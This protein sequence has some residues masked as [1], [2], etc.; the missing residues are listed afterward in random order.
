G[1]NGNNG[2][3]GVFRYIS[4][5][6]NWTSTLG[7]WQR[8]D[9]YPANYGIGLT[10]FGGEDTI[11]YDN[12]GIPTGTH[13][14]LGDYYNQNGPTGSA[15]IPGGF[16][17]SNNY[18]W[19]YSGYFHLSEAIEVS[20]IQGYF[21]DGTWGFDATVAYRMNIWSEVFPEDGPD[22]GYGMPAVNSMVGDVMTS[23]PGW[24]ATS[25][26]GSFG[27]TDTGVDRIHEDISGGSDNIWA[28]TYTLDEPM[29]LEAGGYYFGHDAYIGAGPSQPSDAVPEPATWVLLGA[30]GIVGL[31]RRR[32]S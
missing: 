1:R 19:I 16:C 17:M 7:E 18:D 20:K 27:L 11:L 30:T 10:M 23:D 31:I 24:G 13:G 22:A 9:W 8:D 21:R 15:G 25:A 29:T 12:T 4:D 28:L 3:G 6:P 14:D 26:A 5:N 32:R 2:S